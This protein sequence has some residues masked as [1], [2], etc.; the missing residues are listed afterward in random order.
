MEKI[1]KCIH[2]DDLLKVETKLIK[3]HIDKHQYFNHIKNHNEGI[4]DFINKFGWL[5]RELYCG[6]VCKDR[7]YCELAKEYINGNNNKNGTKS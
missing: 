6:Y 2:L 3:K 5:F 1:K 7:Y 4:R